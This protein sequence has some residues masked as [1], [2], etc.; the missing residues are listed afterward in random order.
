[1]T[2]N[3]VAEQSPY[4]GRLDA[5]SVFRWLVNLLRIF[6]PSDGWLATILMVL[7]LMIVVWSVGT[8]EWVDTPNLV[9]LVFLAMMT[10]LI[11]S[12]IPLWGALLLPIGI[13][14]GGL[15]IVWR[16]VNFEDRKSVV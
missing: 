3:G 7:N 2:P 16:L 12:R 9:G 8:A 15:V 5:D 13:A 10:G 11:L 6:R 4:T 14:I 1:M